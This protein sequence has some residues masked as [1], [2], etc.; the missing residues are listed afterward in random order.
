MEV[1]LGTLIVQIINFLILFALFSMFLFKPLRET[2]ERRSKA[3]SDNI[4]AAEQARLEAQKKLEELERKLAEAEKE[5]QER[6][7]ERLKYAQKLSNSIIEKAKEEAEELKK[8]F[9]AV[10]AKV[11]I[12]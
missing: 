5:A 12:K 9:E 10:G 7:N 8:K 6:L 2:L 3:I 4:R 11:E 1:D